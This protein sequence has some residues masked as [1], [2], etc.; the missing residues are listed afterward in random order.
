MK[1]YLRLEII[2]QD[3]IGMCLDILKKL[4][5]NNMSIHSLEV[6]P[7]KV[8]VKVEGLQEEEEK[9]NIIKNLRNINGVLK[10]HEV[11][12]LS[13]E[14]SERRLHAIIDAVQDGIL[15][16]NHNGEVELFNNYCEKVFHVK[17]ENIVGKNIKE[18]LGFEGRIINLL[19][20][21]KDH[22]NIEV[23]TKNKKMVSTILLQ[24]VL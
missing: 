4:Y 3:R 10:V 15:A 12:L 1:T 23:L 21:G 17:K 24:D 9:L 19:R 6:F 20:T 13:Y 2:S 18:I 14:K 16:I 22:D 8:Y 7:N 11:E 5:E